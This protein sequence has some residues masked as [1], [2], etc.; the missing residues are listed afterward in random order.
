M[1]AMTSSIQYFQ[2]L[3]EKALANILESLCV[4]FHQNRLSRLGCRADTDTQTDTHTDRQTDRHTDTLASIL[5]YSVRMTEYKKTV[6]IH[7]LTAK[8]ER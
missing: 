1:A 5:T 2:N 8:Q 3:R 4:D 7:K 6:V